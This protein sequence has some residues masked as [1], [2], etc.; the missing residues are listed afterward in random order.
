MSS[1]HL[2]LG[3]PIALWVSYLELSSGFHS[4]A[5]H[6]PSL[7][8][9]GCYSQL[10][11]VGLVFSFPDL[12]VSPFRVYDESKH[13]ALRRLN[14]SFVLCCEC[15]S[16]RGVV[17]RRGYR[18]VEKPKSMSKHASSVLVKRRPSSPDSISDFGRLLLL[19]SY[20][21]AQVFCTFFC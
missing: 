6:C 3:L 14:H 8:R 17:H 21:L 12:F 18:C 16:S 11:F 10:D 4:A 19:E 2:L 7:T 5:F 9:Q 13:F 20:H 15:P 1:S